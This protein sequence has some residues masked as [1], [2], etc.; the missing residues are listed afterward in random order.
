MLSKPLIAEIRSLHD[1]KGR[2]TEQSF[3]A[4]GDKMVK[5]VLEATQQGHSPFI[6]KH[7]FALPEWINKHTSLCQSF[8]TKLTEVSETELNK[9]SALT[10]PSAALCVLGLPLT[11]A[12]A[13]INTEKFAF[14]LDGIRDP[15]NLGTL[16]R[17]ADWFG[18]STVYCSPDCADAFA[19]KVIQ[20]T[21]GSFLR[22]Q[23]IST[24]L[25]TLFQQHP[26]VPVYGAVLGGEDLFDQRF[27]KKGLLLI[28]NESQG[29]RQPLQDYITQRVLITGYG[30]AE[31]LNAAV[32]AGIIAAWATRP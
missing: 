14:A 2:T 6:L 18:M 10:T 15:G 26:N 30:G 22:I 20:S 5:E 8:K 11:S 19:P 1:K 24:D 32:S 13:T 9:I 21:M 23:V 25:A 12:A 29:I 4:E 3:I 17:I 27:E 28:G 16:I 7:I 31:S